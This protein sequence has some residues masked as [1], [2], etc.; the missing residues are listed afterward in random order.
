[1]RSHAKHWLR[2]AGEGGCPSQGKAGVVAGEGGCPSQGPLQ[3]GAANA[4]GP[5][6]LAGFQA[7]AL[8]SKIKGK[9]WKLYDQLVPLLPTAQRRGDLPPASRLPP[10]WGLCACCYEVAHVVGVG[11]V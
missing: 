1:M 9:D 3:G 2:G 11:G 6:L 4:Q 8:R 7:R 5:E 10:A